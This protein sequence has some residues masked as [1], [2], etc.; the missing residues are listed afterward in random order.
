PFKYPFY[1]IEILKQFCNESQLRLSS[2]LTSK[3]NFYKKIISG[4]NFYSKLKLKIDNFKQ[5][6]LLKKNELKKLLENKIA[7]SRLQTGHLTKII[8]KV[9]RIGIDK[10]KSVIAKYNENLIHLNP[11]NI[12]D[13][14]YSVVFTETNKTV[15]SVKNV[16]SSDKL[17]IQVKDGK[18]NCEV[19]SVENK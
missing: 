18:I 12:I 8:N 1:K 4:M 5:S 6:E 15:N 2:S 16:K 13:R 7:S 3:Y 19:V 9:L 17:N 11:L 10:R 14:G